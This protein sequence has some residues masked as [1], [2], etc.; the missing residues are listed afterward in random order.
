MLRKI[1]REM[2]AEA[3]I[4]LVTKNLRYLKQPKKSL[5]G[6]LSLSVQDLPGTLKKIM[7]EV[8]ALLLLKKHMNLSSI[9]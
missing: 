2:E 6:A 8:D 7:V 4:K 9:S 3:E 1:I 5:L